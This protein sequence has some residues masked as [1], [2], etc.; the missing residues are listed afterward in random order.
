MSGIRSRVKRGLAHL[1]GRGLRLPGMVNRAH[2]KLWETYGYHITPVHFYQPIP[3]TRELAAAYP[4]RHS[5]T[6]IDWR[7]AAQRALLTEIAAF[8]PE[9]GFPRTASGEA[10]FFLENTMFV[11]ID[12]YVY[13]GLIRKLRPRLIL[14]VGAGFSTLVAAQAAQHLPGTRLVA[15]E[16]YPR[17]FIAQGAYGIE[18]IGRRAED[19]GA[20]FFDQ[21]QAGDFLFIDSSH[22]V[23]TGSDVVFLLLEVLPRLAPGVVIHLHDIF[24]PDDYPSGWLLE[25]HNFWTE[26]YLIHAYL[27]HNAHIEVLLGNHYLATTCPDEVRAAFPDAGRWTGGS[28]WLRVV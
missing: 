27:I 9:T 5:L 6:G 10:T 8:A 12:P 18:H 4:Q 20:A 15:V 17:D 13:Y 14:E 23:R 7:E 28:L 22:V 16:P 3:D 26:Q 1:I 25:K 19:L 11:G 21:L 2:F 24:L